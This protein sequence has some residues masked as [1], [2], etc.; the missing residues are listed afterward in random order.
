MKKHEFKQGDGFIINDMTPERAN[1]LVLLLDEKGYDV[2]NHTLNASKVNKVQRGRSCLVVDEYKQFSGKTISYLINPMSYWQIISLIAPKKLVGQKVRG[3][4]FETDKAKLSYAPKMNSYIG[5]KG[6]V[7]WNILHSCKVTFKDGR[8]WEYPLS[9]IWKHI[10]EEDE[11]EK[12][13]KSNTITYHQ[14]E[15]GF[16]ESFIDGGEEANKEVYIP[17]QG[18]EALFWD[19]DEEDC[20]IADFI[21]FNEDRAFP[22]VAYKDDGKL[23]RAGNCKPVPVPLP[24]E[25]VSEKWYKVLATFNKEKGKISFINY[26]P[27]KS[28]EY[29]QKDN[30]IEILKEYSSKEEMLNE[31]KQ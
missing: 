11:V 15:D 6:V 18:E 1:E 25:E 23:F 14:G 8:S 3:F 31:L 24:K 7:C 26:I 28:L 2:Y 9:E 19:D 16:I 27:E 17:Q 20:T 10:V 21:A 5:K 29:N 13:T 30:D 12:E 4:K 22:Y